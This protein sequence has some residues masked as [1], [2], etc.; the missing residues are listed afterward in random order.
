[1]K[2]KRKKAVGEDLFEGVFADKLR[3]I[4]KSLDDE[5]LFAIEVGELQEARRALEGFPSEGR[6]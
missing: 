1:L 3:A 2:A 5:R 6:A 4:A